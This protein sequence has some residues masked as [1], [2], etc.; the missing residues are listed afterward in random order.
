MKFIVFGAGA[1]G[2]LI[3]ALLSQEHEVTL[4][5][6]KKHMEAIN[7]KG[8]RITGK[9]NLLIKP[10]ATENTANLSQA[11]VIIIT[12]KSYDTEEAMKQLSSFARTSTFLSLQNGLGN[13][14]IISK[15]ASKVI[16]GVTSH[17]ATFLKEGE[18]YHAGIGETVIGNFKGVTKKKLNEICSAFNSAGIETIVSNNI[19]RD[20]WAK[21][22]VNAAIN[23]LTA[24]T[25][26]RNG[27]ILKISELEELM[28]ATCKEAVKVAS[29]AG[30]NFSYQDLIEKTRKVAELTS[31]NESSMLQDV[32]RGK[33]TEIDAINGAIVRIGR[34]K[35]IKTPI[36]SALTILVKGIEKGYGI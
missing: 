21:V 29:L 15:Y 23:P 26:L 33:R 32:K 18:I 13:E 7:R 3:G 17:G 35:G 9:T 10:R 5:G 27:F 28:I 36:N 8:L 2:S 25:R 22:I 14:E 12:T 6:R 4:V 1:L 16:G 31:E 20:I 11:D 24:I 19:R 30:I 34:E